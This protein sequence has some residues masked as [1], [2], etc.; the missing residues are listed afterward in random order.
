VV[1]S[2]VSSTYVKP[3]D[4]STEREVLA[5]RLS[6]AANIRKVLRIFADFCRWQLIGDAAA[7]ML[8]DRRSGG[9]TVAARTD[10]R[11][12]D[13]DAV[14]F[15]NDQARDPPRRLHRIA[16]PLR[17]HGR[18]YGGTVV[19]RA[20]TTFTLSD[21]SRLGRLART[22]SAELECRH[23][24]RLEQ[25]T[26]RL[27]RKLA[28]GAAG[29]DVMY[30]ALDEGVQLTAADHSAAILVDEGGGRW[31]IRAE[32]IVEGRS[33]RVGAILN[34]DVADI[35][36]GPAL[37]LRVHRQSLAGQRLLLAVR[38]TAGDPFD[39]WDREILERLAEPAAAAVDRLGVN[40]G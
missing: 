10:D 11:L 17:P 28:H 2:L 7:V 24:A 27:H 4:R 36:D 30:H 12:T 13:A 9:W 38:A 15:E 25:V 32:K 35:G 5:A 18:L 37:E 29:L 8:R 39:D 16:R 34:L 31:R 33:A 23:R 20:D 26:H 6:R 14:L 3:V 1:T 21:G 19:L 22:I 40:S